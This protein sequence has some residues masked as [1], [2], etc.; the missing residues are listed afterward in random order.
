MGLRP[1]VVLAAERLYRESQVGI[2]EPALDLALRDGGVRRDFE[3]LVVATLRT[4]P[5][6]AA[7]DDVAESVLVG[8]V[9]ASD[10]DSRHLDALAA[11]RNGR[12][13]PVPSGLGRC[14]DFAA[15]P[16]HWGDAYAAAILTD[17]SPAL[18]RILV[19]VELGRASGRRRA[20]PFKVEVDDAFGLG[21]STDTVLHGHVNDAATA[22][23]DFLRTAAPGR[24]ITDL[25][26]I[27]AVRVFRC[28]LPWPFTRDSYLPWVFEL[29]QEEEVHSGGSMG[30]AVGLAVLDAF[31]PVWRTGQGPIAA[32]T[33]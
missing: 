1:D 18:F 6:A 15:R 7:R 11:H 17:G 24:P 12:R 23:V 29:K 4:D 16:S 8:A 22:A 28:G 33:G 31:L 32:A 27:A 26:Q 20:G 10:G 2:S 19:Q 5:G 9:Q 14:L 13:R 3:R 30:L 25:D 21:A